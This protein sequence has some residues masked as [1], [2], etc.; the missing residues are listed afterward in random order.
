MSALSVTALMMLAAQFVPPEGWQQVAS[1]RSGSVWYV[2]PSTLKTDGR[3]TSAWVTM[4]HSRDRSERARQSRGLIEI[5][6]G[7]H[8]FHWVQFF[9]YRPNGSEMD[10]RVE[11][12]VIEQIAPGSPIEAVSEGLCRRG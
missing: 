6:C 1:T 10:S 3:M 7:A 12:N 11:P 8:R 2:D 4:D 5:E 9:S